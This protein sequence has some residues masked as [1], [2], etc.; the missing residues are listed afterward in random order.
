MGPTYTQVLT[1]VPWHA[2]C[3]SLASWLVT[4]SQE[5][6]P[7]TH[8]NSC[9]QISRWNKTKKNPEMAAAK[10]HPHKDAKVKR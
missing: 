2:A 4:S 1:K 8:S 9:P 10:I 7:H 5:Q 6:V 3:V